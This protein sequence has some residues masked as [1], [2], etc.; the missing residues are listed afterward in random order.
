MRTSLI[1]LAL[2]LC[3]LC[4]DVQAQYTVCASSP[5]KNGATCSE[6][7][8]DQSIPAHTYRCTCAH[9]YTNG[10]CVSSKGRSVIIKAYKTEC[11]VQ[12]STFSS[13]LSGN[14]D[15]KVDECISNTCKNGAKCISQLRAPGCPGTY[16]CVC[17]A[18]YTGAKCTID[19]NECLSNPCKHRSLCSDSL[20]NS[21][22]SKNAYRCLC[23]AGF[24]NGKCGYSFI[25]QYKASCTVSDSS[26]SASFSGNCNVDV[27]ECASS[28]CKNKA[29]CTDSTKKPAVPVHMYQCV[30]QA[31]YASAAGGNCDVDVDECKS[32]PC[33]NGATCTESSVDTSIPVHT[34]RCTCGA[35]YSNGVCGYAFV[36]NYHNT[37]CSVQHSAFSSSWTG[38]C[39]V[40]VDECKS[41]PCQNNANCTDSTVSKISIHTY[42]CNCAPG[43][44]NG[45]CAY[46]FIKEY[47]TECTVAESTQ[48]STLKGNCDI[49]VNECKSSPCKHGG[50]CSDSTSTSKSFV[51]I[52]A[53]R[54]KCMPGFANGMCE[55]NYLPEFK[56]ECRVTESSNSASLFCNSTRLGNNSTSLC[57]S[58]RLGNC[59]IDVDECV[60]NPCANGAT[61]TESQLRRYKAFTRVSVTET[62][63]GGI[64]GH[65]TYSLSVSLAGHAAT[66]HVWEEQVQPELSSH[67][68][69]EFSI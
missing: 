24:A 41:S 6:S 32:S 16:R 50:I 40:D 42:Q 28:P 46:H 43:Y 38:N 30:C 53:Y 33:K 20:T 57:N 10:W 55:Y 49:D 12:Y 45:A 9:G 15:M 64:A 11:S 25:A 1:A 54:C 18:G 69:E 5:C 67:N 19:V 35:G 44:A 37:E 56:A 7:T 17:L 2:G 8:L 22:V 39:D 51:S 63:H 61:C 13:S 66:M 59:D 47:T 23:V 58:T 21:A 68:G 52:N 3:H 48:S 65:T 31:G 4:A 60:S 29:V 34:Y 27:D 26:A 14:C 62:G 36:K